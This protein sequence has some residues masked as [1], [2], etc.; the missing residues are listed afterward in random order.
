[1]SALITTR[2]VDVLTNPSML[3]AIVIDDNNPELLQ[4][5][6]RLMQTLPRSFKPQDAPFF[7]VKYRA[8]SV[9]TLD[10]EMLGEPTSPLKPP[11]TDQLRP[12]KAKPKL[13][14]RMKHFPGEI[15]K[16]APEPKAPSTLCKSI[17]P[18]PRYNSRTGTYISGRFAP[19]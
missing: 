11:E 9:P 14:F 8:T 2:N 12:P 6:A 15:R 4:R 16:N 17:I 10:R 1:M 5:G 3:D 19:P 18:R 13:L 7:R